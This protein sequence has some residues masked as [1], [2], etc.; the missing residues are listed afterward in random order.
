VPLRRDY[1]LKEE[2][3]MVP[4]TLRV[5]AALS[6]LFL[7]IQALVS[8][9][10]PSLPEV[11]RE[12]VLEHLL[13]SGTDRIDASI[14]RYSGRPARTRAGAG[15]GARAFTLGVLYQHRHLRTDEKDDAVHSLELLEASRERYG[16][17]IWH[18]VHLG[19][20]YASMAKIKRM[21]GAS[22]I[23]KMWKTFEM[24][25][26]DHPEWLVRFLRGT[27]LAEF[28]LALPDIIFVAGDKKKALSR[29]REELQYV[30]QQAAGGGVPA[31]VAAKCRAL[32]NRME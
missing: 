10:A 24:I 11:D 14:R 21:F 2:A 12:F 8:Q 7:P 32:L 20:T 5:L 29:G 26:R 22:E 1:T 27:T 19:M 18:Q 25:P 31:E 4:D 17:D 9:E 30:L 28:G 13:S 16:N 15:S 6:L 3:I 23:K